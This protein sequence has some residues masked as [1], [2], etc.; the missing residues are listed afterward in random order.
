MEI[1]KVEPAAAAGGGEAMTV[2]RHH[3]EPGALV[4]TVVGPAT[5]VGTAMLCAEAARLI[6]AGD[7]GVVVYDVALLAGAGLDAA[8]ILMR[9]H[10]TARRHGQQ[11]RLRH[12]SPDLWDFLNFVGFRD[13]LHLTQDA[14]PCRN[15]R[16]DHAADDVQA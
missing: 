5:P 9:L 12:A 10:L 15:C 3:T 4:L 8:E 1:P 14:C 16:D 2:L 7:T 6:Q 13:I 11:V